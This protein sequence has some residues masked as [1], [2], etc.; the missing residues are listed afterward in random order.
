MWN[1]RRKGQ[2]AETDSKDEDYDL[3]Y[4]GVDNS[5]EFQLPEEVD[6]LK[7]TWEHQNA[8]G[9]F[10]IRKSFNSKG[11][12]NRRIARL[13][14][15]PSAEEVMDRVEDQFGGGTYTIHPGNSPKVLMT[16]YLSGPSKFLIDGP[17]P[18]TSRQILQESLDE[19]AVEEFRRRMDEDPEFKRECGVAYFYKIYDISPPTQ[20]EQDEEFFR[21]QLK[22]NPQVRQKLFDAKLRKKLEEMGVKELSEFEQVEQELEQIFRIEGLAKNLVGEND[23]D[24]WAGL[25]KV[26]FQAFLEAVKE[27]N[28]LP[29]PPPGSLTDS[30]T[31]NTIQGPGQ[32]SPVPAEEIEAAEPPSLAA[33]LNLKDTI[34][35]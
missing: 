22:K 32:S 30:G 10:V 15:F 2:Q 4:E 33:V 6:N 24:S 19:W 34:S 25:L 16:Y 17:K 12:K 27:N 18:K 31:Q 21:E 13:L 3:Y 35:G 5:Y 9:E 26:V 20:A 23:N 11:I 7:R 29:Q 14:H 28:W 1:K 8:G